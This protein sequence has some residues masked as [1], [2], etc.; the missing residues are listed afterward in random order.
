[1]KLRIPHFLLKISLIL[2]PF[3]AIVGYFIPAVLLCL[4]VYYLCCLEPH[5][6]AM[7]KNNSDFD[8]ITIF[9]GNKRKWWVVIGVLS[10]VMITPTFLSALGLILEYGLFVF[11]FVY[12]HG[13]AKLITTMLLLFS[14]IVSSSWVRAR[15][16]INKPFFIFN[17]MVV[18]GIILF[19][20]ILSI[21]LF[22]IINPLDMD[23]FVSYEYSVYS[24]IARDSGALFD[25][26]LNWFIDRLNYYDL[27]ASLLCISYFRYKECGGRTEYDKP[28]VFNAIYMT[29]FLFVCFLI[30]AMLN[31]MSVYRGGF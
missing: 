7:Q 26:F 17:P 29:S 22:Y 24:L 2:F 4:T 28:F 30:I 11:R 23:Y 12:Y 15:L 16:N 27:F 1:M 13:F 31:I 5:F 18:G 21:P 6:L 14:V 8:A 3:L 9:D 20:G 25:I 19:K 10:A